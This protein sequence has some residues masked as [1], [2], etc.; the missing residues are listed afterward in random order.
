M[1]LE[2]GFG[3][4]AS[5]EAVSRRGVDTRLCAS[6]DARPEGGWI[7]W[8]SHVDWRNERVPVR[9]LGLEGG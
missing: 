3:Q 7:W 6:K 9:T 4:C 1:V 5:E 2:P 8:G